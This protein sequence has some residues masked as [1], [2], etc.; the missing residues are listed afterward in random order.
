M[1]WLASFRVFLHDLAM[2]E[3]ITSNPGEAFRLKE[4][5]Q[6]G[7]FLFGLPESGK[8]PECGFEYNSR[9]LVIWGKPTNVNRLPLSF[10]A[11]SIF[12]AIGIL[13]AGWLYLRLGLPYSSLGFVLVVLIIAAAPLWFRVYQYWCI[14]R[15]KKGGIMQIQ[16]APQ[17][18][19]WRLGYGAVV[20][21]SWLQ[22]SGVELD[23]NR[24]DTWRLQFNFKRFLHTNVVGMKFQGDECQARFIVDFVMARITEAS[25]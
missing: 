4:C 12:Y 2:S 16:I 25:K 13:G 8:C 11:F 20:Y 10:V 9:M 6:C 3:T 1:T 21:I 14:R 22:V 18:V 23:Q 19:G 15:G 24:A 5:P 7:Y 17:G